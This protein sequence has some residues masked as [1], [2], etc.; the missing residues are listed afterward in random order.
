[1]RRGLAAGEGR[2]MAS[3]SASSR[4]ARAERQ[5]QTR[6]LGS[7]GPEALERSRG[8]QVRRNW[9]GWMGIEPT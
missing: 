6:E 3:A 4:K 8:R 9:R 7:S 1:M 5:L 2:G